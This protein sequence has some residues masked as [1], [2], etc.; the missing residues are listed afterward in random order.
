MGIR[1]LHLNSIFLILNSSHKLLTFFFNGIGP[2]LHIMSLQVIE[3]QN[4]TQKQLSREW[5]ARMLQD[6]ILA[7][8]LAKNEKRYRNG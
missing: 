6:G 2:K 1:L 3:E 4:D 8:H 5:N 7:N